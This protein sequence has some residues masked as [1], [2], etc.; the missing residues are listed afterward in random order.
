MSRE[1]VTFPAGDGSCAAWL[2]R[3]EGAA[4]DVPCVVMGHGFSLTRHDG[5]EA[6]AAR[7]VEAGVAVLAFDFRHLGDSPGEPRQRFRIGLQLED[8]RGAIAFARRQAGVDGGRIVLWGYS[9]AA[10]EAVS[11][12][13]D[14]GDGI[15]GLLLIAPFLDGLWRAATTPPSVSAW[16]TP[17]AIADAAGRHVVVPV[18]APPGGKAAMTLPGESDGFARAVSGDSPWRNEISPGIFLTVGTFRPFRK[19]ARV[20]MPVWIGAGGRDVS[21]SSRAIASFAR[22]APRVSVSRY[23]SY[24]HFDFF[25]SPGAVEQ[26]AGDQVAFLRSAGLVA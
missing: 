20:T 10:G 15:A 2:W 16:I 22:R 25:A 7:L 5:L 18:T 14:S 26:V 19:A 11:V 8:W 17:R 24:D 13:A 6:Y 1:D 23:P 4:G 21:V 12:A 9:F 3:P